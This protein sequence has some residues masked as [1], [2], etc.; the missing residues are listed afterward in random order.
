MCVCHAAAGRQHGTK[1]H[2]GIDPTE[3]PPERD[4]VRSEEADGRVPSQQPNMALAACVSVASSRPSI[5]RVPVQR[6][7]ASCPKALRVV[8]AA[9]K[10][11]TQ[12]GSL[13]L[14]QAEHVVSISQLGYQ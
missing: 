1:D 9:N 7:G 12:A 14:E 6:P 10:K 4:N 2:H 5:Q 8:A 3:T 13:L 11:Q